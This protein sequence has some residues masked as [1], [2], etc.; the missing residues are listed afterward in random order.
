LEVG[1][2]KW[3]L[4]NWKVGLGT[5]DLD[6]GLVSW[7]LAIGRSDLEVGASKLGL[8]SW[9]LEV[10]TW[11]LG[12]SPASVRESVCICLAGFS[13]NI[14]RKSFIIASQ[15]HRRNIPERVESVP[16]GVAAVPP[17]RLGTGSR[18]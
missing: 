13:S 8:G 7:D 2:W 5:W 4:G 3:G 17:S 14:H 10:G 11:D 6:L 18:K 15:K 9:K 16:R 1:S 12:L